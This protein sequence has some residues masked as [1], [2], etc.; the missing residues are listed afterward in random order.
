MKERRNKKAPICKSGLCR[1]K[2]TSLF[3]TFDMVLTNLAPN[4]HKSIFKVNHI[5]QD[6][7]VKGIMVC[8]LADNSLIVEVLVPQ[9]R[10]EEAQN[11]KRF[12]QTWVNRTLTNV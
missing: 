8:E 12:T 11:I 2:A 5:K 10:Q 9:L 3:P 1:T 7:E 4:V 6:T